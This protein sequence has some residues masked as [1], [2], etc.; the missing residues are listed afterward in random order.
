MRLHTYKLV[1]FGFVLL[2]LYCFA[3]PAAGSHQQAG[4][5]QAS[6][7]AQQGTGYSLAIE[8][9]LVVVDVL[10]TDEDGSVLSGLR[11]E[12]FRILDNGKPQVI[13]G[14]AS[15]NAPITIVILMEYSGLA[16]DYFAY[17]AAYWGTE[18]L[19]HLEQD[20]WVALVTY[21]MTPAVRVDFTKSK[22]AIEQALRELS[23]PQ[24]R[25]ANM[26][27]ALADTLDQL[28]DVKGKKS[29]LLIST[30]ADTFSRTT[31]D[32]L[33]DKLKATDA[34]IFCIGIAEQEYMMAEMRGGGS[35][36]GYLQMKNQLQT[37][38]SRTGG[39]AWFPRFEG[40]L[41]DLFRSVGGTLRNQ[42][43]ISF[44]PT[45]ESRDGRYHKLNVQV[46][47]SDGLPLKVRDEKGKYRKV[48]IFARE[49]YIAPNASIQN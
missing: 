7:E 31:L 23:Y 34:T 10:V 19:D 9:P 14:F 27:D 5:V 13:G 15:T 32:E 12:N 47:G 29:I 48:T 2:I 49:G 8:T 30:G 40:E 42:Y 35:S 22:P 24:F 45:K 17:K 46:I 20:D 44:S 18:F 28:A 39:F 6:P 25:E 36:I 4:E 3:V 33:Y 21:D 38:A 43:A 11:K 16:Y 1:R 41:P 26:Y 37:F